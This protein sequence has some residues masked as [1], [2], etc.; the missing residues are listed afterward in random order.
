MAN[1]TD[2]NLKLIHF[3]DEASLKKLFP[4][5]N[6]VLISEISENSSVKEIPLGTEILREGQY[7]SVMPIVID[8]VIKVYKQYEERDLL[9]YYIK[10]HEGC[11]MSF[12]AG[13]KKRT[14]Q[15]VCRDR[16]GYESAV[17][18]Y[19]KNKGVD[20]RVSRFESAIFPAVKS[21]VWRAARDHS[22]CDVQ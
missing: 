18:S 12:A 7:V 15:R 13:L 11:I 6:S 17:N 5:L 21:Q 3:M 2:S 16:R 9:L 8:G 10:P 20:Q 4:E 19:G 14:E 1:K 22:G